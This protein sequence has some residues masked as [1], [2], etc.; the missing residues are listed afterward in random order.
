MSRP[1]KTG[2]AEDYTAAFLVAFAVVLFCILGFVWALYGF[3]PAIAAA[4]LIDQVLRRH[5]PRRNGLKPVNWQD[6]R[7]RD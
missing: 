3:L 2:R 1:Q 4:Y 5:P 7:K 6:A